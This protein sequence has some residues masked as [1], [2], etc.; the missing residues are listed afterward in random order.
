MGVSKSLNRLAILG[1]LACGGAW[2]QSTVGV[3]VGLSIPGAAFLVD[4]QQYFSTQIF[5]W[6]VGSTHQVYFVQGQEANGTVANHQY[7]PNP[8]VRYTFTGWTVTGQVPLIVNEALLVVSVE[9]GLSSIIG[10]V[11]PEFQL[12]V[13]FS[14][15]TNPNLACSGDAV[16]NDPRQGVVAILGT[17]FASPGTIWVTAGP[18]ALQA[19][20]FPGFIFSNWL[21]NGN[22]VLGQ[23]LPEFPIVMPS[24]ITAVF[25][26]AKRVRIRSNPPGLSL[27]VDHVVS[28]PGPIVGNAYSGD[29]YCPVNFA[30]LPIGVPV[31]YVP[32]CVGDFDFLP[33]SQHL[34]SAPTIQADSLEKSW[35]FTG[36]SNGMGQNATYTADANTNVPDIISA[37]F[38]AVVPTQVTTLPAGLTVSVDGQNDSTGTQ[39]IWGEGQTHHLSAPA[40]QTDTTGRPWQFTGWSN[41]GT[42]DQNYTVPTG[43]PGLH[44]VANYAPAGKLQV[45]SVPSGLPFVVDG[46]ACTTPCVLLNKPT[47]STVQVVAPASAAPDAVSRYTFGSWNGGSTA[48]SFQVTITDQAQVFTATY[49]AFYK[50]TASTPTNHVSFFFNPVSPDGFFAAGTQVAVTANPFGGF[51]FKRWSGDLS[52]TD[53]TATLTMNSPHFVVAL[54]NG[55]PFISDNGI[56][57]SAGDTPSGTVGPGSDI[58]IFGDD[59]SASSIAAPAGE[60]DQ[61]LGDVWVTLNDRILPLFSISPNVITAQLFSDLADGQYTLTVH[62]TAQMDASRTFTVQRDSPGIFQVFSSQGSPTTLAFHAD[63]SF[64]NAGSPATANET[65]A[66][67]GT[68]FGLYDQ[69]LVDGFLTPAT[70]VWKVVDPV[71]VIVNG[72]TLTP[73]SSQAANGFAGT[74]AVQV[75]LTGTLASGLNDLSVTVGGVSSNTTKLPVK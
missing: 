25:V 29:P 60:L 37:N 57:N 56:K 54:L 75:K 68:G 53:P 45:I 65:I 16:P 72:Q 4:G 66:I 47:G 6:T 71:K 21:I 35:L 38:I 36:F 11:T 69:P 74:V 3:K 7:P 32:L 52:G 17:C 64:V 62:R 41:G 39:R 9:S 24:N 34:I 46:A 14:G 8:G 61:T 33:G 30:L 55:F 59:L 42:A 18:I 2:A 23:S 58:S 26:P 63:G 27:F 10:Q 15:A 12:Y 67:F 28:Q 44:L 51:T 40:T 22:V 73:V 43:L 49:Q 31:G 20:P 5:Q 13:Y 19:A 48:T 70:G 50:L 1:L